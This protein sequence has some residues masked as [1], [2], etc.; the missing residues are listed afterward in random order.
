MTHLN[1]K[2]PDRHQDRFS[3]HPNGDGFVA[4][5]TKIT[6]EVYVGV[7]SIV[8]GGSYS[9]NVRID[10]EAVVVDCMLN[11]GAGSSTDQV[12]VNGGYLCGSEF[13]GADVTIKDS[14]LTDVSYLS[15]ETNDGLMHERTVTIDNSVLN[16][17]ELDGKIVVSYGIVADCTVEDSTV[18]GHAVAAVPSEFGSRSTGAVKGSTITTTAPHTIGTG[19]GNFT[20][21]VLTDVPIPA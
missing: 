20:F 14:E 16:D 2:L 1:V 3:V 4:P 7:G 13:S 15:G 6:D 9:G 18:A 12:N 8:M 21:D 11:G 17:T 10:G 19:S 5:G